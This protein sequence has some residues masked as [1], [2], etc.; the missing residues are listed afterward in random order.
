MF[1]SV[2]GDW[3]KRVDRR[4]DR[5]I[6][7]AAETG[8]SLDKIVAAMGWADQRTFDALSDNASLLPMYMKSSD[9]P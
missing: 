7:L 6:E 9:K 4:L 2:P 3:M 5:M 1:F 8:L